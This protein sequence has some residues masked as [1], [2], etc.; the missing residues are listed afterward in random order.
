MSRRRYRRSCFPRKGNLFGG[1]EVDTGRRRPIKFLF[2]EV[3]RACKS[4]ES[5]GELREGALL[6]LGVFKVDALL[7]GLCA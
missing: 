7:L 5:R 1:T 3:T 6:I 4:R 2:A